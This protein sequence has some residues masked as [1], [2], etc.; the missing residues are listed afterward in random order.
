LALAILISRHSC[1]VATT[2]RVCIHRSRMFKNRGVSSVTTSGLN[3]VQARSRAPGFVLDVGLRYKNASAT[4][5]NALEVLRLPLPRPRL[6]SNIR[7]SKSPYTQLL[8][9]QEPAPGTWV[10]SS[11]LWQ[12]IYG[13]TSI[14]WT[15]YNATNN[16]NTQMQ[17]YLTNTRHLSGVSGLRAPNFGFKNLQTPQNLTPPRRDRWN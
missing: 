14:T 11:T 15:I 6:K 4:A 12:S 7:A 2:K 5:M 1:C 3:S 10:S 17:L 8:D 16:R 13:T 9:K